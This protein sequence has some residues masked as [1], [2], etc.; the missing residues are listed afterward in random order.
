MKY[1]E[2]IRE[3]QAQIMRSDESV[4]VCGLGV[5]DPKGVFGST[6]GLEEEFGS[7]RVFDTPACEN[8]TVGMMIGASFQG[9]RPIM[10]NQRLDFTLVALDQIINHAA[11]WK[12]MFG[13]VQRVPIVIRVIV[14]RGWGQGAQHSQTMHALFAHIPGLKVVAPVSPKDAKGLLISSIEDDDPVIFIE[15]RRL[16]DEE[17]DVPQGIYRVP[18]GKANVVQEGVDI[19][20]VALSH[21]VVETEKAGIALKEQGISAEIIDLRS[22]RPLDMD[23]ILNSVKKTGRLVVIDDD[24]KLC[25]IAGEIIAA[26]AENDHKMFKAPP[27]RLTWPDMPT[28]TSVV[29]E[30]AHY[31]TAKDIYDASCICLDRRVDPALFIDEE[32]EQPFSG[33]F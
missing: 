24:W 17:G 12:W 29:L 3:A 7:K 9:M 8:A 25:G 5:P 22:L 20:L 4:F 14:G 30:S 18:I 31:T 28:P 33:P 15:H 32:R 11:K 26:L 23:T 16:Y 2:A 10:V 1:S 27:I 19:T 6:V 13:G 21:M